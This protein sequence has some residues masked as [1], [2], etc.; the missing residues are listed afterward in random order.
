MLT[1]KNFSKS[2]S[3]QLI[4]E[5]GDLCFGPGVHWLKGENGS[6]KTTFFKSVAG[7]H[8]C[9]G[10]ISFDNGID[11]HKNPIAYRRQVNYAEAEPAY[12]SFLTGRDLIHFIGKAK[13]DA[14]VQKSLAERFG[15]LSYVENSSGTYSSGML[16]KLSIV[17]AFL[18]TPRLIILD[19]P[20]I[21]LDEGAR[22]TLYSTISDFT[23]DGKTMVLMS[24]HQEISESTL[25]IKRKWIIRNKTLLE[26]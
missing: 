4:V 22:Q 12:P 17:L 8:P 23:A 15:I 1:L 26:L 13:G 5:A 25:D 11:L 20:L 24:S 14:S 9:S 10:K 2:Y 3:G 18:G 21:T 19:E 16:K 7:L 6:G